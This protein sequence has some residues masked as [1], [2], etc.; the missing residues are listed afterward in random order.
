MSFTFLA[1]IL[2]SYIL[3]KPKLSLIERK[4]LY[5]NQIILF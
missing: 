2:V 4:I 5:Q 3:V 1:S